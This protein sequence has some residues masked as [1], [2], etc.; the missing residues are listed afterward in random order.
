MDNMDAKETELWE[1]CR[2]GDER[3]FEEIFELYAPRMYR[4][5]SRYIKN[6]MRVEEVVMDQ[7]LNLW[8]RREQVIDG[9]FA[10]YLF[11]CVYKSVTSHL[12]KKTPVTIGLEQ[13]Q[14]Q[15]HAEGKADSYLIERE[16]REEYYAALEKLSPRRRQVYLMRRNENLSYAEIAQKMH[17]S[18][19]AVDN[20]MTAALEFLR[21]SMKGVLS[22][23]ATLITIC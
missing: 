5:V 12:R 2:E 13:T 16:T 9:N 20:H 10:N 22:L 18:I 7:F 23:A 21:V 8:L 6:P 19:S 11:G 15:Y 3:A 4:I 1:R 14:H 17:I